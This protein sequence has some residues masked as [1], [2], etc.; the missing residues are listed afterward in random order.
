[1]ETEGVDLYRNAEKKGYLV[2]Q[3]GRIKT[4]KKRY[5]VVSDNCLYYFKSSEDAE[6]IGIVPLEN[7]A[8]KRTPSKKRYSFEIYQPAQNMEMKSAKFDSRGSV[9]KGHHDSYVIGANSEEELNEWMRVIESNI[10]K[11]PFVELVRKKMATQKGTMRTTRSRSSS[12][13]TLRRR[14]ENLAAKI[15]FKLLHE[16]ATMCSMIPADSKDDSVIVEKYGLNST[17]GSL[18]NKK[19]VFFSCINNDT[20]TQYVVLGSST[21]NPKNLRK[22]FLFWRQEKKRDAFAFYKLQDSAK[23]VFEQVVPRLKKEHHTII[24]GYSLFSSIAGELAL[25][26]HNDGYRVK[27]VVTFGQPR[28]DTRETSE[29]YSKLPLM[30]VIDL[31][32]PV[33]ALFPGYVTSGIEVVLLAD[34]YHTNTEGAEITEFD[35]A[36]FNDS[37]D[38]HSMEYYLSRIQP[39]LNNSILIS[40]EEKD[41]YK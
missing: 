18:N 1:M 2:K 8:V 38:C 33:S 24:T 14:S 30:R 4:W 35:E 29:S 3:G 40:Y 41:K 5:F 6:P 27:N 16:L 20:K 12:T 32:D 7:L 15:N 17:F 31:R 25:L 39:K 26:F 34:K 28:V 19:Y 22:D 37:Q 9:V 13:D 11:N 21:W 10:F 23:K 36:Y